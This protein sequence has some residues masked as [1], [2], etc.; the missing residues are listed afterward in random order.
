ML[1]HPLALACLLHFA[2]ILRFRKVLCECYVWACGGVFHA[3]L[4]VLEFL[5]RSSEYRENND[6]RVQGKKRRVS[7]LTTHITYLC[8]TMFS[9]F[10]KVFVLRK[11][12]LVR[13]CLNYVSHCL[14]FNV[15]PRVAVVLFTRLLIFERLGLVWYSLKTKH[16]HMHMLSI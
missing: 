16:I 14:F 12:S 9:F 13:S 2:G 5:R 7:S 4:V 10:R 3:N 15:K 8:Y 6:V 1:G 11:G